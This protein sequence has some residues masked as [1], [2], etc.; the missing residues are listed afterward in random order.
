VLVSIFV[1]EQMVNGWKHGFS[2]TSH[3]DGKRK[4]P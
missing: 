2:G 3:P 4:A 1:I